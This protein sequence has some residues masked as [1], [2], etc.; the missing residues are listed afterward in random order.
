M[1]VADSITQFAER[2]AF[3]EV[4]RP[5]RVFRKTYH[6]KKLKT[7]PDELEGDHTLICDVPQL[8]PQKALPATYQ[9]I[10]PLFYSTD[11]KEDEII[12]R[13][14]P[15]KPTILVSFGSS[16]NWQ[17]LHLL[18]DVVFHKFN[19]I[20]AGDNGSVVIGNHIIS[21]PFINNVSI[22]PLSDLMICHGGNGTIYQALFCNV[23]IFLLLQPILSRNGI[24][25]GLSN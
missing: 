17:K 4:H 6:L 13:L 19:I 10:G 2:W 11:A 25:I 18:N 9:Y 5:F 12:E 20:T 24:C 16:G 8:F 23:P 15:N 7:Y 22:L 1:G 21:K 3:K 14:N